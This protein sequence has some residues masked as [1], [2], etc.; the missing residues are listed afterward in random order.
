[1]LADLKSQVEDLVAM[2]GVQT[3]K[4]SWASPLVPVKKKE[5]TVAP[6]KLH[7]E[8]TSTFHIFFCFTPV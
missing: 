1:L 5:G 4:S 3:I 2:G 7:S 6:D 8:S